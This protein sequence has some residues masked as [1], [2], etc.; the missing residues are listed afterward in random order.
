[1]RLQLSLLSALVATGHAANYNG[2]LRPQVH[3]S[4]PENFMN[5]PNGLFFD[6]SEGV[7]HLYY[8]RMPQSISYIC[9]TTS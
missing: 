8:Q 1:M 4:P 2:P 5:D 3:Y 9:I 7:Y 6:P